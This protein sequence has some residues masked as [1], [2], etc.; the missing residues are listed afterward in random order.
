MIALKANTKAE[1][2]AAHKAALKSGGTDEGK[3][4]PRPEGSKDFYGAY[5]RDPT[6]NKLCVFVKNAG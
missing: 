6:G 5:M 3:P 1:V 4:G 2:D